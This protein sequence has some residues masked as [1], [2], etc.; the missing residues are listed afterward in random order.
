MRISAL[1]ASTLC[2][3]RLDGPRDHAVL[4]RDV[5]G[6]PAHGPLHEAL[7]EQAHELVFQREEEA[8]LAGVALAAA[9][10]PELVVD[11]AGLVPLGTEH[12]EAPEV[13]HQVALGGALLLALGEQLGEPGHPFFAGRLEALGPHRLQGQALGVAAEEDVDAT[14]GHVGGHGDRVQPPGLATMTA[15]SRKCCLALRTW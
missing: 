8:A 6:E 2:W 4:D 14:A 10:A 1:R 15:A 13:T 9:A 5:L 12:V 11:A 3:A 7:C